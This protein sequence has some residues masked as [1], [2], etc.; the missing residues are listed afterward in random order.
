[1]E[2]VRR[3]EEISR[4]DVANA[5]GK[6]ANLGEL[7]RAGLLVPSGFV[8]LTPAYHLFIESNRIQDEIE[9]LIGQITP[10]DPS[11][12]EQALIRAACLA[13]SFRQLERSMQR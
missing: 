5:G 11:S 8:L 6:G 4:D 3:L 7:L 12:I 2:L 9:R 13:K 10:T 1:M